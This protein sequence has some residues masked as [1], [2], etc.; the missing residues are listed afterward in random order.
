MKLKSIGVFAAFILMNS[1]VVN[2][3]DKKVDDLAIKQEHSA[4]KDRYEQQKKTIDASYKSDMDA[5]KAQTNLTPDQRKVQREAIQKRYDEQKKANQLAYKNDKDALVKDRK[6]TKE[7][8]DDKV[9]HEPKPVKT[10]KPVKT[11]KPVKH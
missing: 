5:L 8:K 9:K 7:K 2:A 10:E 3:Q 4:I 6:E 1:L 11:P